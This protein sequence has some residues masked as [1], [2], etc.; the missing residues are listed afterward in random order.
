MSR[1]IFLLVFCFHLTLGNLVNNVRLVEPIPYM[2]NVITE[3]VQRVE[4]MEWCNLKIPDSSVDL[5]EI[6][7]GEYIKG[8][9]AYKNG[10]VVSIRH[11]DILQNSLGQVWRFHRDRNTTTVEITGTLRMSD[12]TLGF[13]VEAALTGGVQRYTAE[14]VVP[15]ISFDM[16]VRIE[17]NVD[18]LHMVTILISEGTTKKEKYRAV[19]EIII[20]TII[21]LPHS[22]WWHQRNMCIKSRLGVAAVIRDMFTDVI[23]VTV[24][25]TVA[26]TVNKMVFMRTNPL[27]DVYANLYDINLV[28]AG[29]TLWASEFLQPFASNVVENVFPYPNICYNCPV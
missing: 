16:R 20:S 25:P 15:T 6:V 17:A 13:D 2:I 29:V 22:D 1:I 27:T 3:T 9:V 28:T 19:L 18:K 12:V 4:D 5:Y 24:T 26:R 8:T 11:L 14:L 10:F 7:F 21:P 23:N